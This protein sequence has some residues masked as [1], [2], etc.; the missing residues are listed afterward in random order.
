MSDIRLN[1]WD[2]L[3]DLDIIYQNYSDEVVSDNQKNIASAIPSID[4]NKQLEGLKKYIIKN[5]S[6]EMDEEIIH[7]IF[8]YVIPKSIYIPIDSDKSIFAIM[9]DYKFD[10]E[11]G[12][13][14]VY[15]DERFKAVGPQDIIL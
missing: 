4:F 7:N 9:C 11:H 1:I 3:F 13:A 10:M 6:Y 14:V 2:R 12:I 8:R 5:N 15:E